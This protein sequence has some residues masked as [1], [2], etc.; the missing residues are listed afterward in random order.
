MKK[1]GIELI[2]NK[3]TILLLAL[4]LLGTPCL[5]RNVSA[6]DGLIITVQPEDAEVEYPAG[7]SFHVEVDR[8]EDVA[9]YQW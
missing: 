6:D 3:V 9:S 1:H 2:I 7:V 5:S 4:F 8:P